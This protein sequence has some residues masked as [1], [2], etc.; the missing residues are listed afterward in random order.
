MKFGS[1]PLAQAHG[2]IL[3]HS[4]SVDGRRLRK[5]RT[6]SERD[7]E[8]LKTA[9]MSCVTVASLG[10]QDVVE[11]QA[12][13]R[14][15]QALASGSRELSLSAPF[16]GRVNIYS[17]AAGVI[18]VD[19]NAVIGLNRIDPS[20]TLATLPNLARVVP[21]MLVGT[22][23]IVT[24][25]APEIHVAAAERAA[26]GILSIRRVIHTDAGL[27]ITRL[28][29]QPARLA[30]KGSAAVERRLNHLGMRLADTRVVD[31]VS[32]AVSEAL[33][34]SSGSLLLV[35]TGS[36]TS[37]PRDVGP[38]GLRIAGGELHRFGIPV[39]PG[40]LLFYGQLGAR[41]VIGLPGCARSPALNGADW[42]LERI[43][44][45]IPLDESAF[46]AMGI[47][48]LLKEIPARPHPRGGA[49]SAPLR[50][51]VAAIVIAGGPDGV[52][53]ALASLNASEVTKSFVVGTE[54]VRNSWSDAGELRVEFVAVPS[55]FAALGDALRS[56]IQA[57]PQDADAVIL[58]RPES[59]VP[60]A[61]QLNRMIAAYS[62]EDSRDICRLA[63]P[64]G[65]K[66]PPLLL[67]RRFFESLAGLAG[68]KGASD[69]IAEA[70]DLVIEIPAEP[71]DR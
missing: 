26:A 28:A 71:E 34:S 38:E 70:S 64:E 12:A 46:A 55:T 58:V 47:G 5:G 17:E 4:V 24:Y 63:G 33:S 6:L 11:D 54:D 20:I 39:D 51:K 49:V 8:L 42:V 66:G 10:P 25:G 36:A 53:Q 44:C 29:G 60:T 1:M 19:R 35:L 57:I 45:G 43:S 59:K 52:K 56:G 18:E 40:N 61:Q 22:I 2:K 3:A 14:V 50:S 9:G 62:P 13:Q 21:R 30:K 69:V 15:G 67:G 32:E 37:D 27:V 68:N 31:H 41:P 48:G 7:I 16:T 23:K 65:H